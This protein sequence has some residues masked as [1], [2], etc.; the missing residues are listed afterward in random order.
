MSRLSPTIAMRQIS[1]GKVPQNGAIRRAQR[2]WNNRQ[3]T[4]RKQKIRIVDANAI[5]ERASGLQGES[6]PLAALANTVALVV[7]GNLANAS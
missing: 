7:A 1:S 6:D 4:S 3:P 2:R 5:I